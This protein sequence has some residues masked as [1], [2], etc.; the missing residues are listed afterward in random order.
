MKTCSGLLDR[1]A[2][3]Q[4]SARVTWQPTDLQPVAAFWDSD[5]QLNH[6]GEQQRLANSAPISSARSNNSES[7]WAGESIGLV[8]GIRGKAAAAVA[9]KAAVAIEAAAAQLD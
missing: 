4:T 5:G 6:V 1:L 7:S 3:S 2:S 9:T 8:V